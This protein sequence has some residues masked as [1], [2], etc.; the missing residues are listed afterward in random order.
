MRT[1]PNQSQFSLYGQRPPYSEKTGSQTPYVRNPVMRESQ[2]ATVVRYIQHQVTETSAHDARLRR[3][4]QNSNFFASNNN[5]AAISIVAKRMYE[6]V[7][8][9]KLEYLQM[10]LVC[11]CDCV[12]LVKL[13][14]ATTADKHDIAG[15]VGEGRDGCTDEL[16][17]Q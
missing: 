11:H 15:Q 17:S 3:I 9:M 8:S 4:M 10:L 16:V 7:Y 14:R 5:D 13:D 6:A 1:R 2:P 12:S